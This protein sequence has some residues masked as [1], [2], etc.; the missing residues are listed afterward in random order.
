MIRIPCVEEGEKVPVFATLLE[1]LFGY[2]YDQRTTQVGP[3]LILPD[4]APCWDVRTFQPV[5]RI[6]ASWIRMFLSLLD[7]HPDHSIN[8]Q[9]NEEKPTILLFCDFFAT[10]YL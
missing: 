1:L 8:K 2:A 9:K 6:C 7:P 10:F 3:Y 4:W 5:F